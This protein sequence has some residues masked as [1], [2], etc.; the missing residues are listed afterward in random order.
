[1]DAAVAPIVSCV[2]GRLVGPFRFVVAYFIVGV[3]IARGYGAVLV[4]NLR[5]TATEIIPRPL[6]RG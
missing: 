3:R 6:A 2:V 1:M 4:E 5:R